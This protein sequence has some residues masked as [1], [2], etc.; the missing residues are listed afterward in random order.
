[1]ENIFMYRPSR[2]GNGIEIWGVDE[3]KEKFEVEHPLQVIDFLGMM[4][5]AV[6][7]IPGLPGVGEKTA[8]KLL[9]E[10]GSMENL[11]ENTHQ[12]KGKMRE[13]IEASKEIGL[14]SKKLA[15]IF[16]DCPVDF[17]AEAFKLDKPDVEKTDALFQELEFRRMKEQFDKIF[18]DETSSQQSINQTSNKTTTKT[19]D[20]YSLFESGDAEIKIT[21]EGY[22]QTLNTTDHFYQLVEGE[23]AVSLFVKTLLQQT[24]VC[25]DTE[26]NNIDAN[27]AELVGIAFSYTKGSAYYIPFPEDRAEADK[28][29][30]LLKPFFEIDSVAKVGQNL[31]YDI[32]VLKNYG[33][34]VNGFL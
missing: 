1:S 15:T 27:L 32:K 12:L 28:L 18:S 11:L 17:E 34:K 20:Q 23:F 7:N 25:F 10:Y 30:S 6:D 24:E 29:I 5:D 16:L 8:K 2:M 21:D 22:Y 3:V 9:A 13:K 19:E 31:K 33:V 14:L 4:G 26:T